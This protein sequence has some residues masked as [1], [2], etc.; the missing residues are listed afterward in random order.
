MS[1]YVGLDVHKQFVEVCI[2]DAA[3]RVAWR[4][5]TGC[6]RYELESFARTRLK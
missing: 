5:R 6:L 4:G 3:G 1:R 2:L